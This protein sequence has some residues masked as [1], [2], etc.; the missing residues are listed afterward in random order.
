METNNYI[1][2]FQIP[3]NPIYYIVHNDIMPAAFPKDSSDSKDSS[4]AWKV[5]A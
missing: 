3:S 5:Y 1:F 4:I 2:L